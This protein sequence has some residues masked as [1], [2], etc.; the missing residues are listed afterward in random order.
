MELCARHFQIVLYIFK[1]VFIFQYQVPTIQD[2][3]AEPAGGFANLLKDMKNSGI[4]LIINTV[5]GAS[6]TYLYMEA[7]EYV[8]FFTLYL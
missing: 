8:I 6:S 7:I 4:R 3:N 5:R 2:Y 1:Y